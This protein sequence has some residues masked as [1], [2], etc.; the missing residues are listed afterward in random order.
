MSAASALRQRSYHGFTGSCVGL[1]LAAALFSVG[2]SAAWAAPTNAHKV[3]PR[4]NFDALNSAAVVGADLFVTNGANNSVTE[5]NASSGS[6]M[7]TIAG[8]R[9][10]FGA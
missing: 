1:L 8:K 9:F 5:V 4:L 3:Q 10:G 7:T 2:Q 6:Y